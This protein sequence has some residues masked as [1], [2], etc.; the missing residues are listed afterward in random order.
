M[1][2]KSEVVMKYF[3]LMAYRFYRKPEN[4]YLRGNGYRSPGISI[5]RDHER[6]ETKKGDLKRKA[7]EIRGKTR[8]QVKSI[9]YWA[10]ST[11]D[12]K[13]KYTNNIGIHASCL[14]YYND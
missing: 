7:K 8:S 6:Q 3:Q 2:G 13:T 5:L 9:I 12:F 4:R 14:G 11:V 1:V 10:V